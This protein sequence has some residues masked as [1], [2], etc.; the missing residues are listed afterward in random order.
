MTCEWGY[1][2]A[3]DN[4]GGE[5]TGDDATSQSNF[6]KRPLVQEGR[7]VWHHTS[8]SATSYMNDK[9]TDFA[10]P[11]VWIDIKAGLYGYLANLGDTAT[12]TG[13]LIDENLID[14]GR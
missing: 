13:N 9:I 11:P 7:V 3:A 12:V 6:G 14:T 10:D 8:A 5:V 1:D 4:W 2:A